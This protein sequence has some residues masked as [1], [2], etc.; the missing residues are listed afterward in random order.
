MYKF[1]PLVHALFHHQSVCFF[2]ADTRDWLAPR[3]KPQVRV[4][5]SHAPDAYEVVF[6]LRRP[7]YTIWLQSS[8]MDIRRGHSYLALDSRDLYSSTSEYTS[9]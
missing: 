8:S 5:V 3:K 7:F 4:I 9:Y 1:L 6:Y 2:Y